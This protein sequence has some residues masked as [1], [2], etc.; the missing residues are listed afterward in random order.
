V[1]RDFG[2]FIV[3]GFGDFVTMKNKLIF[4][5]N[6]D[7]DYFSQVSDYLHKVFR[8][9]TYACNLCS[10]THSNLGMK[11]EFREFI[12]SIS[13]LEF[14]HKDEFYRNFGNHK[15]D[16]LPAIYVADS[17]DEN[18]LAALLNREEINK[19]NNLDELIE[20]IRKKLNAEISDN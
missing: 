17:D 3:G 10:L 5:Y 1:D 14:L 6:A 16:E 20:L 8:P 18:K 11:P 15:N 19:L 2:R 4:V 13:N 7:A 9:S 12:K